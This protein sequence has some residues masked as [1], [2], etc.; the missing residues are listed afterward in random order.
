MNTKN[1]EGVSWRRNVL[2]NIEIMKQ[3][4]VPREKILELAKA[5]REFGKNLPK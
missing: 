1:L 4:E 3:A 5:A 2:D